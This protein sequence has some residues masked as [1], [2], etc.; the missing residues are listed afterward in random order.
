MHPTLAGLAESLHAASK[1]RVIFCIDDGSPIAFVNAAIDRGPAASTPPVAAAAPPE[2][3]MPE[4]AAADSAETTLVIPIASRSPNPPF[5]D[6]ASS[7]AI[8]RTLA[9]SRA[10]ACVDIL[11]RKLSVVL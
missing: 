1:A 8:P 10:I 6:P 5:A 2:I 9:P 7:S 4:A 3:A 11:S